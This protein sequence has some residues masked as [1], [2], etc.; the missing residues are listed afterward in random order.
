MED[1]KQ[2]IASVVENIMAFMSARKNAE[3][4]KGISDA[5]RKRYVADYPNLFPT[6]SRLSI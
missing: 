2:K 1:K 3:F 6:Y 5:D 4:R